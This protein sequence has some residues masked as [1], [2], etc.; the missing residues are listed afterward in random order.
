MSSWLTKRHL[1]IFLLVS[2][3]TLFAAACASGDPGGQGS[4]GQQGDAGPVGAA[5][6]I[7][8]QGA[9][10]VPGPGGPE[11]SSGAPGATG[12][13]GDSATSAAPS[14][15]IIESA[16]EVGGSTFTL[17]GAGFTPGDT[18]TVEILED[19]S[20]SAP[21]RIS[22]G[23]SQTVNT[24]GAFENSWSSRSSSEPGFYTVFATDNAGREASATLAIVAAK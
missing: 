14:V 16:V 13:T 22:I 1:R 6:A 7:G 9:P 21:P 18:V 4:K 24:S 8:A 19:G 15:I 20:R 23:A 5:G 11:G 17:R 10:G 3:T 2:V 12:P